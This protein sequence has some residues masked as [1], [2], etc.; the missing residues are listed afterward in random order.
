L[1]AFS[2]KAKCHYAIQVADLVCDLDSVMEWSG[3]NETISTDTIRYDTMIFTC[4]QK[5]TYSQLNLPHGTKQ[6]RIMKKLKI[7]TEML[8]RNGPVIK[9]WSHSWGRKGVYGGKDLWT[10]RKESQAVIMGSAASLHQQHTDR[11]PA[12]EDET[13]AEY[14]RCQPLDCD[15]DSLAWWKVP[16]KHH[17]NE[18]VRTASSVL[19]TAAP[20]APVVERIFVV[21]DVRYFSL[22]E[23][24]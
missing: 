9:P 7:K 16:S 18:S 15:S 3:I 22:K 21:A 2:V 20:P 19:C 11:W 8:R 12:S 10:N 17:L 24:V 14:M 4:A 6:K 23:H 5:L 13:G 1:S